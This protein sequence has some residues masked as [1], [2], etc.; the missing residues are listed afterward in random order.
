MKENLM[1]I[2]VI[3]DFFPKKIIL[4]LLSL[5]FI[6]TATFSQ[7]EHFN[8]KADNIKLRDLLDKI[9]A[10]SSY[11]F[12]Y[13][14]DL[15]NSTY[16]KVNVS[17]ASLQEVLKVALEKTLLTFQIMDDKLIVISLKVVTT[18]KVQRISGRITD[19]DT[20]E[21]MVGV[22][23]VVKGTTKGI[24]TD[25]NGNFS[26]DVDVPSTLTFSYVGYMTQNIEVITQKELNINLAQDTKKLSEVVV[27]GFGLSQ[28]KSTLSGAIS[29]VG[30][31]DLSH[32]KTATAAGALVGKISGI[33]FRQSQGRPGDA[34]DIQIRG[35]GT[36]LVVIDGI[37]RDYSDFS[38]LDF[39]DIE[40]VSVLK[41]ASAAIYGM[42]AANGVLVVT[43][44]KGRRNQKP[45]VTLQGYYGVQAP[46]GYNKPADALTYLKSII[47][48]ETY[49]NVP[50]NART[51]TKAEYQKWVDGADDAHKSF[52]WYKYIWQTAPQSYKSVNVSGGSADVD[53]YVSVGRLDQSGMLRN[54]NGFNRT[55]FQSNINANIT[56]RLRI[57]LNAIGRLEHWDQPGL[58]GDDYDFAVNAAFRNLPTK[59]PYANN[60]PKYPAISSVDPQFSYGWIDYS[61]S[62]KF[63]SDNR[64]IQLNGTV[65]YD[66]AKGLKARALLGYLYKNYA[67]G[68][69]EKAPLL[70]SY[71]SDKDK[72]NIAY[73]GNARYIE[74]SMQ[75]V[76]ELS[77]NV[78]LDYERTFGDH[79]LH[80]VT[81]VVT[82]TGRYPKVYIW[83]NPEADGIQYLTMK[84]I[85]AVTDDVSYD[86]KRLGVIGRFNYDY[87]NKYI[88]EFSAR[89]DGSYFYKTGKRFGFF[90]S[91]SLAYR[92]SQEKFWQSSDFLRSK[93]ND[94]KI[95]GSY[96]VLGKELGNALSYIT[97]YNFNQGTAVL[98]GKG[99]VSSKVTGLAT[100]NITWGRVHV[101]DLGF[102]LG[103]LDNKLTAGFDWFDRH[104]T[105]E[106]AS[107]Y[108]V[109]LPNE[110]GFTLPQENLQS[111]HTKGIEISLNWKDK[112]NDFNYSI[113]G[114]FTFSRWITGDR[115]KPHWSSEYAK[116]RDIWNTTGRYR[117][118][119][120]QLVAI[121]QFKSWEEIANYPIDQDH[122]GNTTIRP[123]D[124]KYKDVNHDGYIND[125]DMQNVTY[126]VNGNTPWINFAFNLGAE[127]KG[128]D[129][130]TDFVGG[131]CYTYEQ[132]GYMRYFDGNANVSQYLADN[133]TWYNDIWNKNS[134]FNIGKYPLL[135]KGVNNWMNTQ[136]PNNYW[137][138]NVTYV[139][140]RNLELGYTLPV[141]LVKKISLSNLRVYVS[142]QNLLT[143]T[144]MPGG[145]DPEITSNSGM[146]YPNPKVYNM[147]F[148]VKF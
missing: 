73:Q 52:D 94:L 137:Q 145:L 124:F 27:T 130:R 105:G 9:Q 48:D 129:I 34:P 64:V 134:G 82:K 46:S 38:Q 146:A 7:N 60:N 96:G 147:G 99:V 8:F 88:A 68:S 15:V 110:I 126:R 97:G 70:Y 25:L 81:G 113:G 101:L 63:A 31:G 103:L 91:G 56:K 10:K 127:W 1:K 74:R 123:G 19:H 49:N 114:N 14:S 139:K 107:R 16:V 11:K 75:N 71:D 89:Y 87:A 131:S 45:M 121:G 76:E 83:G 57:G 40:S 138:T 33:S 21:S 102:D 58:P 59:R 148:L 65:E 67:V 77:S 42:Q 35:F 23:V 17:N 55:N 37:Q 66:V 29:T 79:H 4:L 39:N 24:I 20:G 32:S 104:Q 112:I 111:D 18:P 135:T 95:R 30:S 143:I 140:L 117:D 3:R 128:F 22:S 144:N 69:M 78:Q 72:Y 13:R 115:Y 47:Q 2:R 125:L 6:S 132:Q 44:K 84:S 92:V 41:D 54:F 5:M 86:Q 109:Y 141:K 61:T 100:D 90:P 122:Y 53:Y 133:S 108:D 98:D 26:L 36:P 142:A 118:G 50:D 51:V 93:I 80:A 28:R 136:W 120:F 116:Y 119:S 12:L 43:T 85:G 62:G 106:L